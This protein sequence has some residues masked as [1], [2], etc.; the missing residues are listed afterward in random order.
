MPKVNLS[1]ATLS[2]L[3]WASFIPTADAFIK[4][5]IE[6]WATSVGAMVSVEFV[7]ANDVQ[8]KLAAS[9]QGGSGPDIVHIRDNWAQT[10][11][12]GMSDVTDLVEDIQKTYG[13]LYPIFAANDKG[14]DGK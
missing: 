5:Q 2:Y 8:P 9:I 12:Q 13:E 7:N 3:G 6:D 4:K 11:I 14:P 10:F 1:G